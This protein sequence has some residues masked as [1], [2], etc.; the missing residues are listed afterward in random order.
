M[1]RD[2]SKLK[3]QSLGGKVTGSVSKKTDF[4]VYGEKAGSKLTKAQS[5]GIATIDE[6]E[7]IK[8]LLINN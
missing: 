8:L 2:E 5:L 3:I 7:L 6:G 1:T 4:L